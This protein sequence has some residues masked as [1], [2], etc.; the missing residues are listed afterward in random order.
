MSDF[1]STALSLAAGLLIKLV[2]NIP[3]WQGPS[4][5]QFDREV[6]ALVA[7]LE[8]AESHIAAVLATEIIAEEVA[9][10]AALLAAI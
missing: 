9:A 5:S 2:E 8:V 3:E 7:R 4:K 10:R 6:T 1:R